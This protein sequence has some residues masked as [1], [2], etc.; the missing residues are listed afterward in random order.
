MGE[1]G[2]LCRIC[3]P[4]HGLVTS[5]GKAHL[6]GFGTLDAVAKTK[7]ELYEAVAHRGVAVVPTDDELCRREAEQNRQ[8]IGYGFLASPETWT[9]NFH[10]G[11]GLHYD[12]QGC[13]RFRFEGTDITLSVP[14]KPA[15]ISALA[16]LTVAG[17]FGISPQE[18][19]EAIA[20]WQGVQGRMRILQ[21]GGMTI[22][23]DTYNANPA[24]MI[25]AIETLSVLRGAR[26]IAILGDMKELGN[27][28]ESEHRE[29]GRA[30]AQ[31]RFD[32]VIL[33]GPLSKLTAEAAN[34][35]G[36]RYNYFADY[37]ELEPHLAD[38][39]K[40]GDAIL[41]KASRG[42]KLE[43]AIQQLMKVFG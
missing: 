13:A 5:I 18:C 17:H 15:A 3:R 39:V 1:I 9:A 24:S 22:I 32:R 25:A 29:L 21:I 37:P 7:G 34:A 35:V 4:T 12:V 28:A 2:E 27:Y 43:R 16:A 41:V 6:E 14:G 36:V 40:V 31:Y 42:V 38:I 20:T 30:L 23:D 19:K 26:K 33:V 10:R 11:E 8:R